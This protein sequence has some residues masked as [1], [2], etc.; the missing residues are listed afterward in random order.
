VNQNCRGSS[1]PRTDAIQT[2]TEGIQK[3]SGA[4]VD[5]EANIPARRL[6]PIEEARYLLG[7]MGR[8]TLYAAVKRGEIKIVKLGRRSYISATEIDRLACPS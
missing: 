8:S 6:Y 4:L 5:L 3:P 1:R 2:K 7:G